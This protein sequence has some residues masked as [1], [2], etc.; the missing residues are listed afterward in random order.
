MM[1]CTVTGQGA[2]VAAAVSLKDKVPRREVNI[3]TVQTI[4][5]KQTVRIRQDENSIVCFYNHI[6]GGLSRFE[7]RQAKILNKRRLM[8]R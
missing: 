3:S 8:E 6:K 1:C 5:E 2:G 7:T 4:L